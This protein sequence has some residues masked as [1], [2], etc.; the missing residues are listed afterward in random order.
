MASNFH[1]S[2]VTPPEIM[3]SDFQALNKFQSKVSNKHFLLCILRRDR[4][5]GK[6]NHEA[7]IVLTGISCMIIIELYF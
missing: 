7:R 2:K 4:L 5:E 3:F 6:V 1:F